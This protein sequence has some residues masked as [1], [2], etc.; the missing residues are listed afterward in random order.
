[1]N[2]HGHAIGIVTLEDFTRVF[3]GLSAPDEK[4]LTDSVRRLVA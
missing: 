2:H 3:V 4:A 1:V